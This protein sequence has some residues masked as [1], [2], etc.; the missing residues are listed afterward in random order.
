MSWP[1]RDT[2][3]YLAVFPTYLAEPDLQQRQY[4]TCTMHVLYMY[5]VCTVHVQ[6]TEDMRYSHRLCTL[7]VPDWFSAGTHTALDPQVFAPNPL[8]F[9]RHDQS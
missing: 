9:C 6:T 7:L 1:I 5:R 2:K 4:D 3:E 8:H